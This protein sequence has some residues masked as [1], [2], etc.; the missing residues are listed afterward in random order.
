M[1]LL[2]SDGN[3]T[4]SNGIYTFS[5]DKRP[6][7]ATTIRVAKADFQ[8]TVPTGSVAPHV[9]YMRSTALHNIAR[10]KHTAILKANQHDD[11]VDVIAVLEESHTTARYR[12]RD[13]SHLIYMNQNILRD[14]DFYFTDPAGFNLAGAPADVIYTEVEDDFDTPT[15][16][17]KIGHIFRA[18]DTGGSTSDYGVNET[19]N[20]I[21]Q[22]TAGV[23]WKITFLAFESE[24][25]FDKLTIKEVDSGGSET[26]IVD[27][28]S[29]VSLP[30]PVTY[31]ST[32]SKLKFYWV[33]DSSN[34]DL[35]FDIL[36]YEDN[37]GANALL[38]PTDGAYSIS[39]SG[40]VPDAS[41][42]GELQID[43]KN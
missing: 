6:S 30:S 9:V 12:L 34:Q 33:S 19:L 27:E 26:T 21:Y 8:Y 24:S 16:Q 31:T 17:T 36:L 23:N 2:L 43:I 39:V 1:R 32:E 15:G 38:G 3:A 41:W 18:F 29:G 20:R 7:N 28:H 37:D 5:L 13:N 4:K 10:N 25:G 35:G 11:S 40:V 42:F 22:S 14:V